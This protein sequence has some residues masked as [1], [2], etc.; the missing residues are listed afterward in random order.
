MDSINWLNIVNFGL[1]VLIWLVQLI[2]YPSFAH[3]D[4][5][6]FTDWHSNYVRCITAIVSPLML[7]QFFL[8]GRGLMLQ[9]AAAEIVMFVLILLIWLSSF[10]LSVPCHRKLH[11]LGKNKQ[12][13][14]R[15]VLTNWV[16]TVLWSIVFLLGLFVS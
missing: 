13:I 12:I 11:E 9:P 2:I 4:R 3:I 10:T 14:R 6:E 8:A 15:L 7:A 5:E 16:R 1:A